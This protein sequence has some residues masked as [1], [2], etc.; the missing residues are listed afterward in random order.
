[1]PSPRASLTAAAVFLAAAG[2]A[3]A[4]PVTL[5]PG[6]FSADPGSAP[7]TRETGVSIAFAADGPADSYECAL[8]DA[9]F[10]A[11]TSPVVLAGLSDGPHRLAVRAVDLTGPG[12]PAT[13]YWRVDTTGPTGLRLLTPADGAV[14]A[15]RFALL[16]WAPATDATLDAAGVVDAYEVVI[17]GA[18]PLVVDAAPQAGRDT[19][20]TLADGLPDGP[21]TWSVTAIDPLGN[22]SA[23]AASR[24]TVAEPPVTRI[25]TTQ[26][27]WLSTRPVTLSAAAT[28]NGPGAVTYAWDLDGDG[29][30]ETSTGTTPSVTRVFPAGT[31]TVGVRATDAGG[32]QSTAATGFTVIPGP[33]PG[34]IGV[35]I[36]GGARYARSLDVPVDLVW[37]AYARAAVL[38][39]DGTFR[40]G[41]TLALAPRVR[42][43]LPS[44]LDGPRTLYVRFPRPGGPDR[45][46]RDDVIVDR[47][48]PELERV[49]VGDGWGVQAFDATSGVA[50]LQ[51]AGAG[52]PDPWVEFGSRRASVALGRATRVRVRDRAGNVSPWLRLR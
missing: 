40:P 32:L 19:V 38:S 36:G 27:L 33:P 51:A 46:Y 7:A 13:A 16:T 9:A 48:A 52:A 37:P 4:V 30:F 6:P 11:C 47:A 29:T 26:S 2:P 15:N 25:A 20:A 8:D 35:T 28:D 21:H 18:S 22:R 44:G 24:F 49:P 31:R 17:D 42:W 1:M 41:R 10:A 23:P 5:T 12:D 3:A 45:V 50:D 43:R 34:R 14:V 39:N